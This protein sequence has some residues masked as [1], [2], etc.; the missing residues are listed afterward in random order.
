MAKKKK[1]TSHW[2]EVTWPK[3]DAWEIGNYSS[4]TLLNH[5]LMKAKS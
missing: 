2:L 1:V 4:Q 3:L 5:C